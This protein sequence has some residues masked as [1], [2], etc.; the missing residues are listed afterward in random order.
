MTYPMQ[1]AAAGMIIWSDSGRVLMVQTHNRP[2]LIL[3]G[4]IV[5]ADESPARAG[6]REVAEEVGLTVTAAR[7]LVVEHRTSFQHIPSNLQFVF[8][9][10]ER[11]AEDVPLRLQAEEI[12]E[13]KWLDP[14]DAAARTSERGRRRIATALTACATGT[15]V[16]LDDAGAV[17]VSAGPQQ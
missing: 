8:E 3:P 17:P 4:G 13:A 16:H 6:M 1:L 2:H 14:D 11:F 5:E 9:A 15:A 7:L 10:A 12:R